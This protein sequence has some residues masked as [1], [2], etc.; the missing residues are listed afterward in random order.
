LEDGYIFDPAIADAALAIRFVTQSRHNGT[1][2][3]DWQRLYCRLSLVKVTRAK[4][5]VHQVVPCDQP[6]GEAAAR[7]RTYV[8]GLFAEK[9]S[10]AN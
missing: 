8:E 5:S 3:F 6:W 10:N 2:P 1:T 7:V 9:P 4:F